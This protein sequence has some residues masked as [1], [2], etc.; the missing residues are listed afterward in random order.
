[1]SMMRMLY[2]KS[3]CYFLIMLFTVGCIERA[4][5]Q[6]SDLKRYQWMKVF[7]AGRL[8]F[9]GIVHNMDINYYAFSFTTSHKNAREFF[10][11]VDSLALMD[12]WRIFDSKDNRR[13]YV[14]KSD[15]Y[16]AAKH[17]DTVILAYDEDNYNVKFETKPVNDTTG[18][19]LE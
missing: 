15:V 19:T 7:T 16:E 17:F 2:I 9:K 4:K 5:P 12:N 10:S 3:G 18:L 14:R 13:G 8:D 6:E 1:M 11:V